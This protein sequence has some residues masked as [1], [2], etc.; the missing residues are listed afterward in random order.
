MK[1]LTASQFYQ[2]DKAILAECGGFIYCLQDLSDLE[3]NS[4]EMLGLLQ[5]QGSMS[6]KR[7]CQ[8]MQKAILP[9]GEIHGHAHHRSRAL[10][11]P[12]AIGYGRR[13]RHPA[14]GEAIF[15]ENNL[16]ASYLHL[17]FPSNPQLIAQLF[18]K[19][20]QKPDQE[21]LDRWFNEHKTA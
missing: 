12:K 9:E 10:N 1:V 20:L 3:H 7:G 8:G 17:F 11:T 5:G 6:G 13:Q 18:N 16:T 19:Q 15:R 4:F 2:A 14:P 21:F